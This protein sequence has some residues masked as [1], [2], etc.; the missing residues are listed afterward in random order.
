MR[1]L[2]NTALLRW[3]R[4]QSGLTIETLAKRLDVPKHI[5]LTWEEGSKDIS[6]SQ[7]ERVSS[8]FKRPTAFFY[9]PEPP[10]P[11]SKPEDFRKRAHQETRPSAPV[12]LAFRKAQGIQKSGNELLFSPRA[13]DS[14]LLPRVAI[15]DDPET[16]AQA[17][18]KLLGVTFEDQL[19]TKDT[20]AFLVDLKQR[21]ETPRLFVLQ[22]PMP[23]DEVRAFSIWSEEL[24]SVIVLNSKDALS[25]RL[26][27]LIHEVSHLML[28]SGGICDIHETD[29]D[30]AKH[31]VFC[32][33]VAGSFLLPSSG[34]ISFVHQL[35]A[36][37]E[38]WADSDFKAA[39][40]KLKVSRDALLRR[41]LT[42][43]QVSK[44]FYDATAERWAGEVFTGKT[45]GRSTPASRV[46]SQ[47]GREFTR[48][49]LE[50]VT[51]DKITVNVATRLLG[52]KAKHLLKIGKLVGRESV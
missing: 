29:P 24:P 32:N 27:S 42:L 40:A 48:L 20:G 51:K 43:K 18:G 13:S 46:V 38:T 21:L 3:A 23:P 6:I 10:A 31:E 19:A 41:L 5:I 52:T 44:D 9:L 45:M 22:L 34:F 25:A 4:E 7:L 2:V 49:V 26:F 36:E 11:P 1:A 33:A 28:R 14:I 16:I 15:T 50:N 30:A 47:V 17:L 35:G 37:P 39:A 12:Q 8:V